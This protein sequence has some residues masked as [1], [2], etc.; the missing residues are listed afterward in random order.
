MARKQSKLKEKDYFQEKL[1]KYINKVKEANLIATEL[2]RDISLEIK[3]GYTFCSITEMSIYDEE[4]RKHKIKIRVINR[5]EGTV[6]DWS[7]DIFMNRYYLMKE[8][9]EE[10]FENNEKQLLDKS[11]DPFWDP[12]RETLIGM[13]YL[14]LMSLPYQLDNPSEIS[15]VAE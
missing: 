12:S 3:I 11:V 14:N 4:H 6:Y 7:V 10:H 15:L 2:D 5:E 8:L 1:A 9:L 13:G